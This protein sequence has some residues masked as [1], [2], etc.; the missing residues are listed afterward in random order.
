MQTTS[1]RGG[2]LTSRSSVFFTSRPVRAA[3]PSTQL[4]GRRQV[5]VYAKGKQRMR[6]GMQ[7]P[8]MVMPPTPPVDPDNEEFVIFV[9]SKKLPQ[10]VPLSIMKGGT[11]A[12]ML[13]KAV[14]NDLGKKMYG[15]QLIKNIAQSVYRDRVQ[16]EE[17]IRKQFPPFKATKE[18]EFGFKIRDKANPKDWY[19]A[20]NVELLP[21]ESELGGSA[22]E[23]AKE[24]VSN[25]LSKTFSGLTGGSGDKA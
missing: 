5:Q 21:P 16:V 9:R 10:W 19:M 24:N 18:F 1:A 25:F 7:R 20:K 4:H 3:A 17:Q 8:Q 6:S 2:Q 15:K 12:N 11:P 14:E 13:V 22:F 23:E